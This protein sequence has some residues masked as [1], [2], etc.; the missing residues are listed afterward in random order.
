[1]GVLYLQGNSERKPEKNIRAFSGVSVFSTMFVFIFTGADKRATEIFGAPCA[2]GVTKITQDRF[3]TW[4]K[5]TSA[6]AWR[7]CSTRM[8]RS[9]GKKIRHGLMTKIGV[10]KIVGRCDRRSAARG[11]SR[12]SLDRR[13]QVGRGVPGY[14]RGLDAR[15]TRAISS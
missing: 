2:R 3:A 4:P 14:R 10:E 11:V 7:M 8:W 6:R 13:L 9:E 5:G 1:M 12:T 15:I